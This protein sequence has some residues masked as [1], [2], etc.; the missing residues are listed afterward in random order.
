MGDADILLAFG[1]LYGCIA[2]SCMIT[3]MRATDMR[4]FERLAE[5]RNRAKASMLAMLKL[6]VARS[7]AGAATIR[8]GVG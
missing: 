4:E 7:D 2:V 1:A 5:D 6:H 8:H 3:I